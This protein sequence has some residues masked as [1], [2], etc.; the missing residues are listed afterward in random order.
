MSCYVLIIIVSLGSSDIKNLF[1][2]GEVQYLPILS[3]WH[4]KLGI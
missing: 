3:L 2:H 1:F 4:S